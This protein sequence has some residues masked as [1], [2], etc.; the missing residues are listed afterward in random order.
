MVKE[1]IQ[2]FPPN[3][4]VATESNHQIELRKVKNIQDRITQETLDKSITV[5]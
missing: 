3:V 2:D 5:R 1:H 4:L